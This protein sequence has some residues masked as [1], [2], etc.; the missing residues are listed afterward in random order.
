MGAGPAAQLTTLLTKLPELT[1]RAMID[2]AA[3]D[4][5]FMNSKGARRRLVK[6]LGAIPRNRSDLIPYYARLVA[7]LQP[8]MPR[9]RPRHRSFEEKECRPL[10]DSS[11]ERAILGRIDEIQGHASLHHLHCF[12]MCLDD[13]AG[14]NIE[15]LATLLETCGR[16]LLRNE[17]TGERTRNIL[18][19]VR[20]K[21]AAQNSRPSL[22]LD[23]R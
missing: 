19:M 11:E 1:N 15:N 20:R 5:A 3:V 23:A 21:R 16:Y 22:R 18:E 12:K 14:P 17:E 2:S 9:C 6:H 7:T 4:F 8:Y 13:F 10:R